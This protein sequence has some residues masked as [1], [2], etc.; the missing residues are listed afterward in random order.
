LDEL[1]DDGKT[2]IDPE[3]AA[4]WL[5]ELAVTTSTLDVTEEIVV[6]ASAW[7]VISAVLAMVS[8]EDS[9]D[10]TDVE[11]A[12]GADTEEAP[13]KGLNVAASPQSSAAAPTWSS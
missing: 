12:A 9:V 8:E 5:V 6:N 13:T 2:K 3:A 10:E 4:A 7:P 1:F 11:V